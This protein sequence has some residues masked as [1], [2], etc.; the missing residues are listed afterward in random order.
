MCHLRIAFCPDVFVNVS[1]RC[2]G[3]R[4]KALVSAGD[5]HAL[6]GLRFLQSSSHMSNTGFGWLA[7][8]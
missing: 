4:A 1:Q 5:L 8:S 2:G 6:G 7:L 3:E